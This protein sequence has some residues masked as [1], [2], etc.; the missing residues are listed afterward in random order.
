[1]LNTLCITPFQRQVTLSHSS[2]FIQNNTRRTVR[3]WIF[4]VD[5]LDTVGVASL[6]LERML[7]WRLVTIAMLGVLEEIVLS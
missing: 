6:C 7:I 2:Y 3:L 5:A 1:M 4:P